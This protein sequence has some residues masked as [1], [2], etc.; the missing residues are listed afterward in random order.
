MITRMFVDEGTWLVE[1]INLNLNGSLKIENER[2]AQSG[3]LSRFPSEKC[4]PL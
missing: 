2:L 4:A 1:A 3:F